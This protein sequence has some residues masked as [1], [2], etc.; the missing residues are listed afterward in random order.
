[1]GTAVFPPCP[2][3]FLAEGNFGS[4]P[5]L[6]FLMSDPNG[7]SDRPGKG[8]WWIIAAIVVYLT[9]AAISAGTGRGG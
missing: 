7:E 4:R 2:F 9:L 1:M 6:L 3:F 5:F 8:G